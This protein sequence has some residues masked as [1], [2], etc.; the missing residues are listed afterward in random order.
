MKNRLLRML[1][2]AAWSLAVLCCDLAGAAHRARCSNCNH[3]VA[4]DLA[5]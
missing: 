2:H 5:N 3:A 4:H 1:E